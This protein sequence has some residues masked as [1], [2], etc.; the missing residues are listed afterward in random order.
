MSRNFSFEE[1]VKVIKSNPKGS[2]K[3]LPEGYGDDW[4]NCPGNHGVFGRQFR[5][6]V[7]N[8]DY[9]LKFM[10]IGKVDGKRYRVAMYKVI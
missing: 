2:I 1:A 5:R 10:G 6:Y 7:E 9:G 4:R 8:G 3:S